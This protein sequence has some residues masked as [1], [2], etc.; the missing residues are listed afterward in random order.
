MTSSVTP[1]SS[2]ARWLSHRGG[3]PAFS[4][5]GLAF[6]SRVPVVG[7]P[8]GHAL[9]R[10]GSFVMPSIGTRI[11]GGVV[12]LSLVGVACGDVPDVERP[13][14]RRPSSLIPANQST[15]TAVQDTYVSPIAP[16]LNFD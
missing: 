5:A 1:R 2:S 6:A 4:G 12:A 16:D 15:A 13:V 9:S 7:K 11:L 14:S 3:Y 10:R 8:V